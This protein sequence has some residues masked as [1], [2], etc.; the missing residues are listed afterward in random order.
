MNYVAKAK[1]SISP[2][3]ITVSIHSEQKMAS[4]EQTIITVEKIKQLSPKPIY[5]CTKRTFDLLISS[6]GLVIL[7][8]PMLLIGI[9]IR[10]DSPGPAIY[11]QER[12]GFKGK[13]FKLL[14]FR[15]MCLDAEANGPQWAVIG[16]T[17]IT[18]VGKFL[19]KT[20][21][22]ELPQLLNILAG[23]IS[24][25]GPRPEREVFYKEFEIYI[26]GFKQRLMVKPGLTGLA[27][28]NGGYDLQPE[29]K[30]VFDL[31]YIKYRSIW[32]DLKLMIKTVIVVFTHEGAR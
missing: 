19:R 6:I 26:P 4:Y 21:L 22:D 8:L 20:R 23:Q 18:K 16:D 28:I 30:I 3:N 29:E 17:R 15:S 1:E 7:F 13:T 10:L 25:V 31:E 11:I 27:Q 2:E 5:Q 9:I 12:L 14:K 24:F 32:L